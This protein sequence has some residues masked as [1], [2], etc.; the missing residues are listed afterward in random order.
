MTGVACRHP[1]LN[2]RCACRAGG[3]AVLGRRGL[4]AGGAAAAAA[5]ASGLIGAGLFPAR[6]QERQLR[7]IDVHHHVSPP[8]WLAAVQKAG[9]DN[10]PINDWTPQRSLEEMDRAGVAV[11]VTSPTTPQVGFLPPQDAARVAREANEYATRLQADHPGRFGTFAMLP[12]PNIDES[13][14]EIA[15]AF[16]V[17]KVD[18]VGMMTNYGNRWLGNPDFA[19]VFEELNRLKATVYTH[20]TDADCCVNLVR[21][22]PSSTVEYG[23][24]TT[25]TITELI[26]SGA[27]RRYPDINFIFS[28]GGGVL[29]AVAERLQIQMTST[30]PYKDKVSRA[31]VDGELRRFYYD[32]AQIAN[33]VTIDALLQLV[34][35]SQVL[36]GSDYPYRTITE[37][38]TGLA[39]RLSADQASAVERGNALRILPRL[40]AA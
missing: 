17:L 13:L 25:R 6:A 23:A 27:S 28:H 5:A 36:L 24:N 4:L 40:R 26:F 1:W 32:T 30:P 8:S 38:V 2:G 31:Q 39:A 9:L 16:D 12:L 11:A 10:P 3:I 22:I 29:T 37:H 35:S 18:G 14:T 19:P 7:R 34:P 33:A 15:H 20:P 21:G